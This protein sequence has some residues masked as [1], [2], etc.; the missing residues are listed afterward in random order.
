[1][2]LTWIFKAEIKRLKAANRAA[3]EER[4]LLIYQQKE[5]DRIKKT[6]QAFRGKL[7]KHKSKDDVNLLMEHKLV[8]VCNFVIFDHNCL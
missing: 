4:K 3:Q 1:M 5:I 8:S 7:S 2:Q 6:T